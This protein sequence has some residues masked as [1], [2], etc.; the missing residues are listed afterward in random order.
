MPISTTTHLDEM[1]FLRVGA[2]HGGERV[3][4]TAGCA[5]GIAGAGFIGDLTAASEDSDALVRASLETAVAW[6][7][8]RGLRR[9]WAPLNA[10]IWGGYRLMTRGFE[11]TPFGGEPR[12]ASWW[13]E[14]LARA[15][16]AALAHWRSW[17]LGEREMRALARRE[18]PA[19]PGFHL[20]PFEERARGEQLERL[21]IIGSACFRQN[22]AFSDISREA[23]ARKF[24]FLFSREASRP[25]LGSFIVDAEGKTAG[26]YVGYVDPLERDRVVLYAIGLLPSV[27]GRSLVRP[28]AVAPFFEAAL[29]YG[30]RRAVS[31]LHTA[32]PT[33][34]DGVAAASRQYTVFHI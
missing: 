17:D 31:A 2:G 10:S 32:G 15:G 25:G 6:L 8:A 26:F 7:R 20:E 9:I 27:R 3:A 29:A 34:L 16:F 19:P 1:G 21:R 11:H 22:F 33:F 12:N 13:P 30:F 24:T 14:C 23:F 5:P 28:M 4:L 18:R